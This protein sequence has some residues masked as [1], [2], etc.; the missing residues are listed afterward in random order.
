MYEYEATARDEVSFRQGD[1]IV[2]AMSIDDGSWMLGTVVR[3]GLSGML[4]SNYVR[5]LHG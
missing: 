2:N 4:P 3:T 5:P 1:V